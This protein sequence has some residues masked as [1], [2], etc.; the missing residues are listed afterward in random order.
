MGWRQCTIDM[1]PRDVEQDGMQGDGK[2]LYV[3]CFHV[4]DL[5]YIIV[6]NREIRHSVTIS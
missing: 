2:E 5:M 1:T 6:A 4:K 3:L